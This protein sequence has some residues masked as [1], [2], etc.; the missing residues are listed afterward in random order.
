MPRLKWRRDAGVAESAAQ[1]LPGLAERFFER[2]GELFSAGALHELRLEIKRF[3]Y[4][5]ELFR[6][7][8]GPRLGALLEMLRQ[9]QQLL[10]EMNDCATVARMLDASAPEDFRR[11]L[12]TRAKRKE[13]EFRALW[14][15]RLGRPGEGSRWAE[16]LRR[17]VRRI[18]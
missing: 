6:E 8:Y 7:L 17:Y 4:T 11:F 14:Q 3:R 9:A 10:G 5:L 2:A 13:A 1:H 18:P 15:K 16:Y 12:E